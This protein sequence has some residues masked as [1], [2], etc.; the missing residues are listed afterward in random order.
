MNF[1]QKV[2][3][4]HAILGEKLDMYNNYRKKHYH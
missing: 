4:F 3:T 2:S 1:G